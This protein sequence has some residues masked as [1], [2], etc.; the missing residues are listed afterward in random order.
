MA[1]IYRHLMR[2]LNP[3]PITPART[4]P[5]HVARLSGTTPSKPPR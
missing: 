5:R 3:P 1:P 2:Q 4:E